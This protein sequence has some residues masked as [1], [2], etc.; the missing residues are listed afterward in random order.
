MSDDVMK[1]VGEALAGVLVPGQR[2]ELEREG[3][4]VLINLD[5]TNTLRGIRIG[6]C[7]GC[8][9]CEQ[10]GTQH[11]QFTPYTLKARS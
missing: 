11:L 3:G 1:K 2:A 6:P 8:I 5:N 4:R 9:E 10:S 7:P